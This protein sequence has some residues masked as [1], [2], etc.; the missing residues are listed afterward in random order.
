MII[1]ISEK[2]ASWLEEGL[3]ILLNQD[4]KNYR[5][6][7]KQITEIETLIDLIQGEELS[8]IEQE[9]LDSIT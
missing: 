4:G 6:S 8:E 3:N 5:L 9:I 1:E 2:Q 7:L